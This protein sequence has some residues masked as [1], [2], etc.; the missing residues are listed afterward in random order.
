MAATSEN[1]VKAT[2]APEQPAPSAAAAPE[3]PAPQR[4]MTWKDVTDENALD[5]VSKLCD[6]RAAQPLSLSEA[7]L[8][9]R[10]FELCKQKVTHEEKRPSPPE[11]IKEVTR[12][13]YLNLLEYL[14]NQKIQG[15]FTMER[16]LLLTK[17]LDFLTEDCKPPAKK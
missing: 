3:Q 15:A 16:C 13:N 2:A 10:A 6:L 14:L 7:T 5:V 1:E 12:G 11:T 4:M 8:L 17:C 9:A